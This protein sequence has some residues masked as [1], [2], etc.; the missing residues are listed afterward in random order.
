MTNSQELRNLNHPLRSKYHYLENFSPLTCNE[1]HKEILSMN[2]KT[3]ELDH[4][5]TEGTQKDPT[6]NTRSHYRNSQPITF[7]R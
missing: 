3:C 4:I 1:V 6:Y 7:H 5:P 2:N